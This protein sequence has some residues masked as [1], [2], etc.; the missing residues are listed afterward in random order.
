[1]TGENYVKYGGVFWHNNENEHAQCNIIMKMNMP[2]A[3]CK[4]LWI[5]ALSGRGMATGYKIIKLASTVIRT[6]WKL[7]CGNK[8]NKNKENDNHFLIMITH[9]MKIQIDDLEM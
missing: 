1:M 4:W 2:N 3:D 9:A 6:W 7:K 8:S 5:T